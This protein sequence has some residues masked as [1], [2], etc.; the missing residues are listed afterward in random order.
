MTQ[1]VTPWFEH[2]SKDDHY[3]LLYDT[4]E[5]QFSS[6]LPFIEKGLESGDRCLYLVHDNTESEVRQALKGHIDFDPENMTIRNASDVYLTDGEFNPDQMIEYLEEQLTEAIEAGYGGLRV[7][8]ETSWAVENDV[9]LEL[10]KTYEHRVDSLFPDDSLKAVCQYRRSDWPSEF[11]C[12]ILQKHPQLTYKEEY[13]LNS[14]YNPPNE[15]NESDEIDR[16]LKTISDQDQ[17]VEILAERN[18]GLSLLGRY[19]EQL[20]KI[21][22]NEIEQTA[23]DIVNKLFDPALVQFWEY[24]EEIGGLESEVLQGTIQT[25]A[26]ISESLDLWEVYAEGEVKEVSIDSSLTGV[27][28]PFGQHGVLLVASYESFT[29]ADIAFLKSISGHT[30]AALDQLTYERE[31]EKKNAVLQEKNERLEQINQINT[32]IRQISQSLVDA[33]REVNIHREVCERLVQET[34]AAFAWYG[35]FD[36]GQ[37]EISHKAGDGQGYLD[38]LTV[39]ESRGPAELAT[40][41]RKIITQNEINNG[42]PLDHW[43]KQ[44]LKRGFQSVI[45]LPVEYDGSL[46]GVLSVYGEKPNS[47]TGDT[48]AVL[49][50]LTNLVAYALTSLK[51]KKALV[52]EAVTE[53]EVQV[54]SDGIYLID[55][56]NQTGATVKIEDIVSK[57]SGFRLY[58]TIRDSSP[59]EIRRLGKTSPTISGLEVLSNDDDHCRCEINVTDDCFMARLVSHNA[60]PQS[61]HVEER[62]AHLVL[63]LP[64]ETGVRDFMEMLEAKISGVEVVGRRD[65]EKSLRQLSDIETKMG[66]KLTERQLEMLTVAYHSGYFDQPRGR[67]AEEIADSFD[68]SHAT[69]TRHLREAERRLFSMFFDTEHI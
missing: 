25:G 39:D 7:T 44:A 69:V 23:A 67:T 18:E 55:F 61:V 47:F 43:Q 31:L 54:E 40:D 19:T 5:Q 60:I 24:N 41:T 4:Q 36:A 14:F 48:E 32:V 46:Y 6:I 53:L 11:L 37:I 50:E 15:R 10:L 9:D 49:D 63:H 20:R 52:T 27:F 59:D 57:D 33:S 65:R 35:T 28:L 62:T 66:E 56:V 13:R 3:C 30:E 1:N 38:A 26:S 45:S 21:D 68:V 42:H 12:D 64:R 34:G 58:V 8:G 17:V 16:K 29:E 51:R 22:A 2:L